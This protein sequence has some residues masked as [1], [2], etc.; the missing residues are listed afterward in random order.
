MYASLLSYLYK[1]VFIYCTINNCLYY[2]RVPP[3]NS[4]RN[5]RVYFVRRVSTHLNT[6]RHDRICIIFTCYSNVYIENMS[7]R[8]PTSTHTLFVVFRSHTL[9]IVQVCVI[10]KWYKRD[11]VKWNQISLN[12]PAFKPS[13]QVSQSNRHS[14]AFF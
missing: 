7:Y 5:V 10:Q 14:S 3:T 13:S 11:S 6:I 4:I 2:V 1:N 9:F 8:V 12:C